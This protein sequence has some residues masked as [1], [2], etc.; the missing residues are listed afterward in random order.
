LEL[1]LP[2]SDYFRKP[3]LILAIHTNVGIGADRY[4]LRG[5]AEIEKSP[6]LEVGEQSLYL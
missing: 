5:D 1:G 3:I 6:Q 2:A 4:S